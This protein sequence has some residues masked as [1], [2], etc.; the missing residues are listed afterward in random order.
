MLSGR[1]RYL[2]LLMF[3]S[4]YRSLCKEQQ[5]ASYYGVYDVESK[6]L[7]L[8]AKSLRGPVI[9]QWQDQPVASA[10]PMYKLAVLVPQLTDTWQAFSYG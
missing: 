5:V 7:G 3:L 2:L 8:P 9:E 1:Y 10:S 6:E 4:Q